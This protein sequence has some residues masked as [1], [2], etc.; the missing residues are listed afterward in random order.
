MNTPALLVI[1]MQRDFLASSQGDARDGLV[2]A[3]RELVALAG[4]RVASD[5][6]APGDGSRPL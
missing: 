3:V 2:T 1:D 5:L 6:G 4:E